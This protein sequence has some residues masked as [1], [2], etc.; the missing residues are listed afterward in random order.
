MQSYDGT[1]F[2]VLIAMYGE[3]SDWAE[4]FL[5]WY[6]YE[7]F[8]WINKTSCTKADMPM[9]SSADDIIYVPP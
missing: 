6:D 7:N 3:P 5:L 2:R 9:A 1:E 4:W 8:V